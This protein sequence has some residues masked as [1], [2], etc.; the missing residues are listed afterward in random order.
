MDSGANLTLV[1]LDPHQINGDT[2]SPGF[3]WPGLVFSGEVE[4]TL[5]SPAKLTSCHPARFSEET[6]AELLDW[7]VLGPESFGSIC[8][9]TALLREL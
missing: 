5:A 6:P 4:V 3:W 8:T 2:L 1:E 9:D 7:L